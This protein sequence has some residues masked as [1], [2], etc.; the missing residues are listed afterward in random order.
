VP[1]YKT[2]PELG[3]AIKEGGVPREKLYVVTK[4][5]RDMND[6]EGSLKASLKKLQ[7]DYVNLLVFFA[8]SRSI[9]GDADH[10]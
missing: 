3:I 6:I 9:Q 5:N 10:V 4:C 2:E 8:T 1:V 7:L